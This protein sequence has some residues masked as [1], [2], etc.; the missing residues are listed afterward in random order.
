MAIATFKDLCIYAVDPVAL[1]D[2]WALDPRPRADPAR[3]RGCPA[4]R[5]H[6][7]ARGV[8]QQGARAGDGEQ[9]FTSTCMRL[10][11]DEVSRAAAR[12]RGGPRVLPLGRPAR[13]RGRRALRVHPRR[14][15]AVQALRDRRRR[16][17]PAAIAKLVGR[18]P[19]RHGLNTPRSDGSSWFE[20]AP[21]RAVR[22]L[23]LRSGARTQDGQEPHPLGRRCRRRA[24]AARPRA[25]P[26]SARRT[27]SLSGYVLADPEGNEFCAFV[28]KD[29]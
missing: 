28:R 11:V 23:R 12:R 7:A 5:R 9:R 16:A 1:G 13:S 25:R 6:P 14:G 10:S 19:R 4:G 2:F 17:D 15:A 18:G 20:D 3:R 29:G 26:R 22:L 27:T 24:T 21:A 8:G